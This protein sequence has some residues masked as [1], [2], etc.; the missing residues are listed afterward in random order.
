MTREFII[1]YRACIGSLIYLLSTKADLSFA[2]HK[3]EEFS[4]NPGKV[5]FE[6]L[7]HLL[8]YIRDNKTLV[9]KYYADMND[10]PV[11]DLLRQ[12]SIKTDNHLMDFSDYSWQYCPD[13][14][15]STG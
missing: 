3:L 14:S 2:V 4:E 12:T 8:S 13:T 9:L 5:H 10:A 15:R 1:H 11:S 6:G 7:V